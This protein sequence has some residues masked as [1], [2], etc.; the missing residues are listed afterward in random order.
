MDFEEGNFDNAI[1]KVGYAIQLDET[2]ADYHLFRAHLRES[3]QD[4]AAA[5]RDEHSDWCYL[6]FVPTADQV[7]AARNAGKRVLCVGPLFAEQVPISEHGNR[8]S[9]T[10][11]IPPGKHLVRLRGEAGNA[12]ETH[13]LS[14]KVES[15]AVKETE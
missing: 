2:A 1:E 15:I 12:G 6:R 7:A 3:S 9:R 11:T 8:L 14:F 13:G 5:V 4:L 10:V